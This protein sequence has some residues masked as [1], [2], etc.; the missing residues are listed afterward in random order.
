MV[1]NH[2]QGRSLRN[3][4]ASGRCAIVSSWTWFLPCA[5]KTIL[6]LRRKWSKTCYP[7]SLLRRSSFERLPNVSGVKNSVLHLTFYVWC[8]QW[9]TFLFLVLGCCEHTKSLSPFD[10]VVD[11]T[12]VIRS[13]V[14]KLLL[15][16]RWAPRTWSCLGNTL[17]SLFFFSSWLFLCHK[18]F[19]AEL[20]ASSLSGKASLARDALV[21]L[22]VWTVSLAYSH[23]GHEF[24]MATSTWLGRRQIWGKGTEH[25]EMCGY[26]KWGV[27]NLQF[28]S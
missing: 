22:S 19:F 20:V 23:A 18:A 2:S 1:F 9:S 21:P 26:R 13:V 8:E 17:T 11:K 27:R 25:C 6:H 15:K 24:I 3:M 7:Y 10:D 14:L 28:S 4:P 5:S 12:P 16:Y